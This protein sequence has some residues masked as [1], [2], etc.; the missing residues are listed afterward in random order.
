[1]T[2]NVFGGTL[3]PTLLLLYYWCKCG[4]IQTQLQQQQWEPEPTHDDARWSLTVTQP[5]HTHTNRLHSFTL[6]THNSADFAA[7]QITVSNA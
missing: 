7:E 6:W 2:Y 5:P 3:N 1:M 4:L